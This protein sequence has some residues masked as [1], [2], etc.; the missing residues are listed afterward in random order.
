MCRPNILS[1][2]K[3]DFYSEIAERNCNLIGREY[4]ELYE[5]AK[6]MVEFLGLGGL[7][8]GYWIAL[9]HI[10]NNLREVQREVEIWNAR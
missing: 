5:R 3:E 1:L 7:W 4:P 6:K 2:A 8:K 9:E 10:L